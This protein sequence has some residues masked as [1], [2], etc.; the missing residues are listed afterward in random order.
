MTDAANAR[1]RGL[2]AKGS[3]A[4]AYLAVALCGLYL[5]WPVPAGEMPLSADHLVHLARGSLIFEQLGR[6][7]LVGWS[8]DWYFGFPLGELYPPLGDLALAALHALGL[9][10]RSAYALVFTIAFVGQ[11][12]ALVRT[13]RL[14]GASRLA[15]AIAGLL[16]LTDAGSVREGGW[17]YTV[18]YGVWLQPIAVALIWWALALLGRTLEREPTRLR[19]R[20]LVGPALALALA[21]L[22]HPIAVPMLA[23]GVPL[24]ALVIGLRSRVGVGRALLAV[25]AAIGV[26][27]LLAAWWFIPLYVHRHW[28]S[29]YGVIHGTFE[30]AAAL[31]A[32]GQ[33]AYNMASAVGFWIGVGLLRALGPGSGR[34]LR[35]AALFALALYVAHIGEFF[36]VA[37]LDWLS[38]GFLSIQCQRF[39]IC[40]KPG[41]FVAGGLGL[42]LLLAPLGWRWRALDDRLRRRVYAPVA[43]LASAGLF[44]SVGAEVMEVMEEHEV[45]EVETEHR[46][47]SS[48]QFDDDLRRFS[49]WARARHG[50]GGAF[51]RMAFRSGR[52][53]HSFMD[54]LVGAGVPSYKIG[55][56]PGDV[57]VHKP[58]AEWDEL[59][60][61]LRVRY[62][63][64]TDH[65]RPFDAAEAAR[66][67]AIQVW[68][69]PLVQGAA[70]VEGAG[71]VEVLEEDYERGEIQVKVRGADRATRLV[72]GV[73]GYPR[74]QLLR[75]GQEVEWIEVPAV[76]DGP[77]ATQAERRAGVFRQGFP[78]APDGSEPM[79]I[80]VE[81]AEDGVYT[82]RYRRWMAVDAWALTAFLAGLTLVGVALARP[83]P[84]DR[85]LA[86]GARL[87]SPRLLAAIGGALCL[88][89]VQRYHAGYVRERD[90]AVGWFYARHVGEG[91][92]SEAGA[93]KIYRRVS[94]AVLLRA[95]QEGFAWVTFP[96]VQP[97]ADPGGARLPIDGWYATSDES[98]AKDHKNLRIRL[99]LAVRASGSEGPWVL[100]ASIEPSLA[101]GR[102][103]F[104][105]PTGG[106]GAGPVDVLVVLRTLSARE[107]DFGFNLE[108]GAPAE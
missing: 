93:M 99:D 100:A 80:A 76:G 58:E 23:A 70:E 69:L 87:L 36:W 26:G 72:F 35:F 75:D 12:L 104:E 82:L 77:T 92:Q 29:S 37:R 79:L 85:I 102:H 7:H 66:F 95:Y 96:R 101:P 63:V 53:D 55:F 84:L 48:P 17:R 90:T 39:L 108:L 44:A 13:A 34:L 20:A 14:L 45:G 105:I 74:W 47:P 24:F 50:E 10:L 28:M 61:R 71:E 73:A 2:L 106:V 15:A 103:A 4:L 30:S 8:P 59:L 57:F 94:P 1:L 11:G 89:V 56:T 6:G 40:A 18:H 86:G 83:A 107:F 42:T 41:L 78:S 16:L 22:A 19:A 64:T 68:E 49:A 27:G 88:V 46:R 32:E 25:G 91:V 3:S 33:W 65:A 38:E 9:S 67:G 21:L 52:H 62:L 51:Y 54:A 31:L 98:A 97:Q 43:A 5:I 81:G 60:E